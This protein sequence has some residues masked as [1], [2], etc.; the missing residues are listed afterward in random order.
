MIFEHGRERL[1]STI[2]RMLEVIPTRY[3][4]NFVSR[5]NGNNTTLNELSSKPHPTSSSDPISE[6]R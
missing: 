1:F 5:I 2:D 6:K 3:G 4:V